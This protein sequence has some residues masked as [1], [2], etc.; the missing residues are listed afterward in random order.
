MAVDVDVAVPVSGSRPVGSVGRFAARARSA[1]RGQQVVLAAVAAGLVALVA[2]LPILTASIGRA[3]VDNRVAA[4]GALGRSIEARVVGSGELVPAS[5]VA[6]I[7]GEQ[8]DGLAGPL[9]SQYRVVLGYTQD[10]NASISLVARSGYCQ[11][12][13]FVAGACPSGRFEVAVSSQ[14]ARD[15]GLSVGSTARV[16][17]AAAGREQVNRT[18]KV[19]GIFAVSP[20]DDYWRGIDVSQV[21]AHFSNGERLTSHTWLTGQNS[22][23][24]QSPPAVSSLQQQHPPT[25]ESPQSMGWGWVETTVARQLLQGSFSYDRLDD[26]RSALAT[27]NQRIGASGLTVQLTE[28]VSTVEAAVGDDITQLK[29]IVPL[30]LA[31]LIVLQAALVWIVVRALLT[32]RRHEVALV[33]LRPIGRRGAR[34]ML[35]GE[36]CGPLLLALPAGL[37]GAYLLDWVF[38]RTWLA[39][40]SSGGWQWSGLLAAVLATLVC[41]GALVM[42][43]RALVRVPVNDLLRSVPPRRRKWTLSGAEVV[44][45]T[46]A[47][48]LVAAVIFG[49]LTGPPVLVTPIVVALAVG[50]IAGGLL[51]PLGN[52][53]S[54]TL[55]SRG[56]VGWLLA[57]ARMA[58]R[59]STRN[60]ILALTAA[61]AM[62]TF[63]TAIWQLGQH[64]R[65]AAAQAS[66]GAPVR[67]AANT[68]DGM[69]DAGQFVALVNRFDPQHHHLA[70]VISVRSGGQD[71]PVTMGGYPAAMS[72]ITYQV[73]N[74][75]PWGMLAKSTQPGAAVV[76]Q[77]S[78]PAA[79]AKTF[80][81]PGLGAADQSFTV[82]G[83]ATLIPGAGPNEFI[84]PLDQLLAGGSG[85]TSASAEVWDD[86][87]D[88]QL[89]SKVRDAL[90]NAGFTV[91]LDRESDQLDAL[92]HSA[93]AYG[94]QLGVVV[95]VGAILVAVLVMIAV[96]SSQLEASRRDR[97]A[98]ERANVSRRTLGSADRIEMALTVVP[99]VIGAVFGWLGARL[100]ARS[101]PWF[102]QPPQYPVIDYAPPVGITAIGCAVGVVVV[103]GAATIFN[104]VTSGRGRAQ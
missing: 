95:A 24:G 67:M 85:S 18:V 4:L 89:T 35:L 5:R 3:M 84:T 2:L 41:V 70:P 44:L 78:S 66:A 12:M 101:V 33:R 63:S 77:W 93:S 10:P 11:H 64:N 27:T 43:V 79:G 88:P 80:T 14:S 17:Q 51:V 86:D 8:W 69:F 96:S 87:Q 38:R 60:V 102:A 82:V 28:Q 31:Q 98:L 62:L 36:L 32:Q 104:K 49:Y 52:R 103:L 9:V 42:M 91:T 6:P 23:E 46:M 1:R 20:G 57:V 7:L 83:E 75:D 68:A 30:L 15:L 90:T 22:M 26:A 56:A 61:G 81:A 76:A 53:L 100:A 99:V 45:L 92:N 73:N 16:T 50:I 54:A 59:P 40:T 58:R 25:G 65:V 34:R 48:A 71:G 39:G 72:R 13:R 21:G 29:V 97:A 94:L 37:L 19:A 74:V 47:V 55:L